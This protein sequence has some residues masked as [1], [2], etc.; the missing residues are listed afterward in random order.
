MNDLMTTAN[1]SKY[2]IPFP[3][4]V[5][6]IGVQYCLQSRFAQHLLAGCDV[7]GQGNAHADWDN[8]KINNH[9]HARYTSAILQ[10][11]SSLRFGRALIGRPVSTPPRGATL[12][13]RS[14]SRIASL[15][16]RGGNYCSLASS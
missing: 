10:P 3:F 2:L 9:V 11:V 8:T 14:R 13:T 1:R 7:G 5:R 4:D 16:R 15:N 6:A 12:T